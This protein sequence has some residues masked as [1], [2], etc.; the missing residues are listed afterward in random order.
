[1]KGKVYKM[2]VRPVM[3][4]VLTTKRGDGG[5]GAEDVKIFFGR[6]RNENIGGTPRAERVREGKL[7]RFGHV[8]RGNRRYI[9]QKMLKLEEKKM[10]TCSGDGP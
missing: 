9:G 4:V 3:Y 5:R 8:Q 10:E 2:M 7:R 1:M 6:I